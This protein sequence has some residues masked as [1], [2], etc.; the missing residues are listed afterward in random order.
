VNVEPTSDAPS[1]A[2][3]GLLAW[4]LRFAQSFMHYHGLRPVRRVQAQVPASRVNMQRIMRNMGFKLETPAGLRGAIQLGENPP[5]AM[6]I[7]GLIPSDP[8]KVAVQ[9][10]VQVAEV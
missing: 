4:P 9:D 5:E 8:M 6:L 3:R 10:A 2:A 1:S 7:Y